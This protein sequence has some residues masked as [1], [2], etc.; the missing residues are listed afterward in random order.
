MS[1]VQCH[2]LNKAFG[3]GTG[4]TPVLTDASA[5]VDY[6]E[7]VALLGPSGSGKST[8]LNIV[9]LIETADSGD[10]KFDGTSVND[11][12]VTARTQWRREQVGF[13]FQQFNLIPVMSVFDN[14]AFPLMLLNRSPKDIHQTVMT[15]LDQVGLS[16][17]AHSRPEA[18]SGGQRQRVAI[19]RA[20]VKQPRLLIADEP[21]ASLDA[22]TALTVIRLIRELVHEHQTACLIATHDYRLVPFCDRV[23]EVDDGHLVATSELSRQ[24]MLSPEVVL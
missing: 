13:I 18:L 5:S 4:L 11:L 6:G 3:R 2:G 10:L 16:A 14:V 12:S 19:A 8:L 24:S 15:L 22:D 23:L 20:L 21:T 1:A 7:C 9:G 17:F